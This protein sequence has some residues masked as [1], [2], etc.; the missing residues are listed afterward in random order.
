L[1]LRLE[2][3]A[4]R[5]QA[6][7]RPPELDL[8]S[9]LLVCAKAL[10][11]LARSGPALVRSGG[12]PG[13]PPPLFAETTALLDLKS[14]LAAA[15]TALSTFADR[16]LGSTPVADFETPWRVYLKAVEGASPPSAVLA[17]LRRLDLRLVEARNRLLAHR[18]REHT[19]H[20]ILWHRTRRVQIG[21]HPTSVPPAAEASMRSVA[22]KLRVAATGPIDEVVDRVL[23]AGGQLDRDGRKRVVKLLR[24][25]GYR[26]GDPSLVVRDLLAVTATIR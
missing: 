24:D 22:T 8:A 6:R 13:S 9:D 20:V 4:G 16:Q 11:R 15:E 23:E 3:E 5:L 12:T 26:S 25:V 19:L 21:L 10:R 14:F 17:E 7:L 1:A 2:G 18:I